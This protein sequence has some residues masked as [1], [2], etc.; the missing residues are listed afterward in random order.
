M[1]LILARLINQTHLIPNIIDSYLNKKS[2]KIF[3]NSFNTNDGYAVRDYI[4]VE[5]ICDAHLLGM[6]HLH[7][8][9][10]IYE[11]VNLGS[12]IGYSVKEILDEIEKIIKNKISYVIDKPKGTQI[13]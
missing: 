2:F 10:N 13:L 7:N 5:D 6:K 9:N 4:H 1:I 8:S 12:G 11:E 3:G